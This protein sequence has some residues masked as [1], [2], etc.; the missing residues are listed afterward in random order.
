M[1]A[2]DASHATQVQDNHAAYD[3]SYREALERD[4]PGRVALMHD[5]ELI[6]VFGHAE[7]AYALG[8]E[9]YGLGNFSYV[10]IGERPVE[11]GAIA[12]LLT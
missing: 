11:I 7:T 8:C 5:G 2:T 10:R 12:L 4:H 1:A 6:E 3:A 9:R